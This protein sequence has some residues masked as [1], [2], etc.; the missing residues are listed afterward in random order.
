MVPSSGVEIVVI[1]KCIITCRR[2]LTRITE[3][4]IFFSYKLFLRKDRLRSLNPKIIKR[5]QKIGFVIF[6]T[7]TVSKPMKYEAI[8]SFFFEEQLEIKKSVIPLF[9]ERK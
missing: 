4:F 1:S 3:L 9:L 2:I 6:S 7:P 5:D 8:Y